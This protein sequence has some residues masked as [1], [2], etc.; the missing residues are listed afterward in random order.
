MNTS[1][2]KK[3]CQ[4][5]MDKVFTIPNIS[6]GLGC[7]RWSPAGVTGLLFLK[8][9]L[10]FIDFFIRYNEIEKTSNRFHLKTAFTK[11]KA[12]SIVA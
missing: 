6:E 3:P 9:F 7:V 12:E 11:I 2:Y 8:T 10:Y 5:T 1:Y 4:S